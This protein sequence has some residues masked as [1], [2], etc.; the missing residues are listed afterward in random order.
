MS[1][2]KKLTNALPTLIITVFAVALYVNFVTG[3]ALSS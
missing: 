1:R 2:S 3:P